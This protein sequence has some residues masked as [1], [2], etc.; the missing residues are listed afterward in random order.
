MSN[1]QALILD[2]NSFTSKKD[3]K[4]Y[5]LILIG[6][7][8]YHGHLEFKK[9]SVSDEVLPQYTGPGVYDV[10]YD[11]YYYQGE[12]RL[13]VKGMKKVKGVEF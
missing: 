3:N 10:Q 13:S 6:K 1:E 9:Q 11:F 4:S 8:D 5:N 7:R 2:V 12:L